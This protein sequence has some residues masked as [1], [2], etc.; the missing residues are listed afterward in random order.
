MK[1]LSAIAI[2]S[3]AVISTS[4]LADKIDTED[5]VL[6]EDMT[7]YSSLSKNENGYKGKN[8]YQDQRDSNIFRLKETIK[9]NQEFK[10]L[11]APVIS[12]L[13]ENNNLG[14]A[15]KDLAR[16]FIDISKNIQ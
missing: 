16:L 9:D 5:L 3:L 6:L 10:H 8:N 11:L 15:Q 4:A 14:D 1:K 2:L 12:Y 7:L 13:E